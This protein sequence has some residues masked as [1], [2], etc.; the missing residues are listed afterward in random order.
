FCTEETPLEPISLYGRTK[1]EAERILL[2]SPNVV[3]LR[4]ATVFGV[5]P[6]MRLDLLVNHFV[7]P[8]VT[9]RYLVIFEKD[10]KR[11]FVH[12]RDVAGASGRARCRSGGWAGRGRA[13]A[14]RAGRPPPAAAPQTPRGRGGPPPRGAPPLTTM[15]DR[16][17]RRRGPDRGL[18]HLLNRR[19]HREWVR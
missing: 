9:D 10:F 8:A 3:A 7:H 18:I 19:Y 5:S 16:T 11:N 13:R 14:G 4:L 6:R 12:V 1:V 15:P 2:D 17:S